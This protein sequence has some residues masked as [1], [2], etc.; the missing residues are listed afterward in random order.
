MFARR[1]ARVA[2]RWSVGR[3]AAASRRDRER[4]ERDVAARRADR[5]E[6]ADVRRDGW[7]AIAL[8]REDGIVELTLDRPQVLNAYNVEMRDEI[9]AALEMVASDP[10]VR[11]LVVRG[12]GRA[13]S[14]GGDLTEFGSAPSPTRA[15]EVRQVRD[16]WRRWAG[17]PCV[18]IAEVHGFAV[19]GGFEMALLCDLIV[20]ALDARFALPE[21]GIG[22]VPGVG[23]TQTLPR[24]L[25]E[26]RAA[27]VILAGVWIDGETAAR[28][29]LA[30]E[31]VPRRRLHSTV[32]R[33]ARQ[34][35]RLD[36]DLLR[37]VKECVVRGA[38]LSLER[39]LALERRMAGKLCASQR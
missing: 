1:A 29:G 22:L 9:Y 30:L 31:A 7:R 3:F 14:T 15:R 25:G 6:S 5:R 38:G 10:A 26:G 23:G 35:A 8:A 20:C 4:L 18:T 12:A 27:G 16:V 36:P 32:L 24:V 11:V 37:G 34:L 19:G 17:L 21:T 2:S 28:I 13:F 39:A 33:L